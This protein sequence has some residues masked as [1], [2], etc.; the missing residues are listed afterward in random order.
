MKN[1]RIYILLHVFAL[2]IGS[3]KHE[4]KAPSFSKKPDTTNV[5]IDEDGTNSDVPSSPPDQNPIVVPIP[6]ADEEKAAADI[7]AH[8][9]AELRA[10]NGAAENKNWF[11]STG[12]LVGSKGE[13]VLDTPRNYWGLDQNTLPSGYACKAEENGC[14]PQFGRRY[15][16]SD[17]DCSATHTHCL[18]FLGTI[19]KP[20]ATSKKM[21]LGSG[22]LLMNDVYKTM[23]SAKRHLEFTSLLPASGR[24]REVVVNAISF[25]SHQENPPNIR[26]L[27]GGNSGI[28]PNFLAPPDKILKEL[29]A[30][31]EKRGGQP[32][33][34]R[35]NLAWLADGK[36]S[37]NHA[38][39]IL[40]DQERLIQGGHNMLDPDYVNEQ[41]IF[42]I[43]MAAQGALGVGVQRYINILWSKASKVATYPN[44]N[45][46][47][48]PI[49]STPSSPGKSRIL[50]VGRLGSYGDNAGD[51]AIIAL[52]GAAKKSIYLAQQDIFN[53]IV[54][55]GAVP[56]QALP[57]LADAVLR[58]I[59]LKVVQSTSTKL[60]GYGM[61]APEKAY[62]LLLEAIEKEAKVRGFKTPDG[63]DLR[64][65]LC[66]RIDYSPFLFTTNVAKWPNGD[67]IG[68]HPKVIIVDESSFF[69]GSQNFYP[70]D[71]Q[72][73]S[74]IV[75]DPQ[76]TKELL[77]TYFNPLWAQSSPKKMACPK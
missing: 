53:D 44:A 30:D 17:A 51:Q 76:K 18:E 46:R 38:K 56:S 41:P 5:I 10:K 27:F 42:D 11:E 35:V 43:S 24:F 55:L 8:V 19:N 12:D 58:G 52:V 74:L 20:G 7:H 13:W 34:L 65:Y 48:E 47:I 70:S 26:L 37:W 72:E 22:D 40:A 3:C 6:T 62:K 33:R 15:C 16:S 45:D 36:A 69:M 75:S 49:L 60:F 61:V 64:S 63:Q 28:L 73:F 50:G 39:I 9:L 68:V 21:C 1:L 32:L 29:M 66:S 77:A 23:V 71:L 25:L 2:M 14:D 59:T 67:A 4:P 31:V 57:N 54:K